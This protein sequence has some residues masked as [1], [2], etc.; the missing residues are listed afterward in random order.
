MNHKIIIITTGLLTIVALLL[1][2]IK[3][4]SERIQDLKQKIET[5][6]E[7][8]VHLHDFFEQ[9]GEKYVSFYVDWVNYGN[10]ISFEPKR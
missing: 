1:F 9:Q 8:N 3:N 5:L 6:E 10:T 4:Q 7:K 2:Q